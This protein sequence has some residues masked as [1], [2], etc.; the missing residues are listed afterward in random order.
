[1]NHEE[2]RKQLLEYIASELQQVEKELE[3]PFEDLGHYDYYAGKKKVLLTLRKKLEQEIQDE[4]AA[5]DAEWEENGEYFTGEY[6]PYSV[7]VYKGQSGPGVHRA[8][9]TY[10]IIIWKDQKEIDRFETAVKQRAIDWIKERGYRDQ[11]VGVEIQ[12]NGE[13]ID[14]ITEEELGF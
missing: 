4:K 12:V 14:P 13:I 1:M 5:E 6:E 2:Y 11:E 9:D 7:H 10:T 3:R 8:F